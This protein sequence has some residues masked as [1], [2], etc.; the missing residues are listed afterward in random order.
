MNE[1][2]ILKRYVQIAF[3]NFVNYRTNFIMV[4]LYWFVS[5]GVLVIFWK[6]LFRYLPQGM[7]VWDF[8]RLCVLNS[9]CYISWGL[10]VL[11][12]GLHQI[13]QKVINGE[14]DKYLSRPMSPLT[15][16]LG[17]GIYLECIYEILSGIISIVL[18]VVYYSIN[19]SFINIIQFSVVIFLSTLVI[20]LIHGCLSLLAFWFGKIDSLQSILDDLDNF[21]KYPLV[22]FPKNIKLF[23]I[24]V[25]PLYF[26]GSFSTKILLGIPVPSWHWGALI[27][28]FIFW[29]GVFFIMY[30][31]CL[32]RYEANG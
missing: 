21:Q 3:K 13:P 20:V 9:V 12:W 16:F 2:S 11:F 7:N 28:C 26:P 8:P 32:I 31:R 4:V 22:F 25:V 30:K 18:I 17:E 10:F 24:F 15:G 6:A 19:I 27:A 5:L 1:L 29:G 23:L 14:V